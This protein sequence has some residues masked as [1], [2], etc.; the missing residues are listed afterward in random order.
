MELILG[1]VL[2][3]SLRPVLACAWIVIAHT[4]VQLKSGRRFRLLSLG[5]LSLMP[6]TTSRRVGDESRVETAELQMRWWL[7]LMRGSAL[8]LGGLS[9]MLVT[10]ARRVGIG[11]HLFI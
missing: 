10:T 6:M 4:G 11:S 5:R 8:V 1:L 3:I 7:L 9:M 2:T